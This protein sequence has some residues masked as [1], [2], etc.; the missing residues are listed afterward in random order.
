M[1]LKVTEGYLCYVVYVVIRYT[2]CSH[3]FSSPGE[4]KHNTSNVTLLLLFTD[5]LTVYT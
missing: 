2:C 5:V 4:F 1:Q 3:V